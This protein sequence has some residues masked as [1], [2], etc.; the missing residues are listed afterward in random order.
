M[1]RRLTGRPH[2]PGD[3]A[4][5]SIMGYCCCETGLAFPRPASRE[6]RLV[7]L[8]GKKQRFFNQLMLVFDVNV[9]C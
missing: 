2:D 8:N 1:F 3:A 5:L 6:L 7:V 9:N 4:D